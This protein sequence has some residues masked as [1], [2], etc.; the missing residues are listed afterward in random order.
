MPI[1]Q[2]RTAQQANEIVD[3]AGV[4]SL[5]LEASEV[6]EHADPEPQEV[7]VAAAGAP[8][9]ALLEAQAAA[10]AES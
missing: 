8:G 6:E 4:V 5:H 10:E 2:E 7:A 9:G 3:F 1:K